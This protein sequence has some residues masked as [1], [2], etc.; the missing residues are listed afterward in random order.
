MHPRIKDWITRILLVCVSA[1]FIQ[2]PSLSAE[3]EKP[4]EKLLQEIA[5][6]FFLKGECQRAIATIGALIANYPGREENYLFG[7]PIV[8]ACLDPM[9]VITFLE[10]A[11]NHGISKLWVTTQE[12]EI[13][14]AVGGLSPALAELKKLESKLKTAPSKS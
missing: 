1:L 5:E 4:S 7:L 13:V 11:K 9:S 12:I 14:F 10:H 6:S 8:R 3:E 2:I